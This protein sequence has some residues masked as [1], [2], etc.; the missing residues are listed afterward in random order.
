MRDRRDNQKKKFIETLTEQ[1]TVY[2]P[3]QAAG[4]SRMTASHWQ[5]DDHEFAALWDEAMETAV[6]AVGSA[7]SKGAVR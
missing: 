2:C 3:A 7:L 5:Q 6:D 4:V 1:C